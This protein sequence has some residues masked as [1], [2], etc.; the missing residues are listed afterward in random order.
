MKLLNIIK[1]SAFFIIIAMLCVGCAS[2]HQTRSVATSGFLTDYSQLQEGEGDEALIFYIDKT[3]AWSQYDKMIIE[4]VRLVA[5][6][7]SEMAENSKEELQAIADYF[8]AALRT[9][10]SKKYTVVSSPGPGTLQLRVALTDATGSSVVLDTLSS[11]IPV[12]MAV[13]VLAKVATGNN[14]SVG[15]ATGEIEL[16]DSVSGN[17]LAAAVDGRSG[18]KYSGKFDKWSSWQ[19]TKDACDYW[20]ERIELRLDELSGSALQGYK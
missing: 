11:I 14:L 10:L 2:T 20:A 18:T 16:L 5:S 1:L 9:N 4:P 17:R 13:N 6:E 15:S 8:Y 19:D 7:D 3:A 12:G